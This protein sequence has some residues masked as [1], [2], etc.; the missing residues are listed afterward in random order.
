M[1]GWRWIKGEGAEKWVRICPCQSWKKVTATVGY[2]IGRGGQ[3]AV[4]ITRPGF[5]PGYSSA[6]LGALVQFDLGLC[7]IPKQRHCKPKS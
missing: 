7:Q 1:M 3:K 6:E 2:G 4:A 5:F